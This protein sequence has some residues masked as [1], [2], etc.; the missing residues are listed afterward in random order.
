MIKFKIFLCF[1]VTTILYA[2]SCEPFVESVY[3]IK[4]QNNTNSKVAYLVSY[5]YPDTLI[6]DQYN[7]L[8]GIREM[9]YTSFDSKAKFDDVFAEKKASKISFFFFST[10]TISKYGWSNIKSVYK[11]LKRKDF[12]LQELKNTNYKVTYP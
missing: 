10:D 11:I 12:T 2:S 4:V 7:Q 3:F 9:D 1:V 8:S 5:N 6:P